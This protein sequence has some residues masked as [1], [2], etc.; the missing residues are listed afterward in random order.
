MTIHNNNLKVIGTR[1]LQ[2]EQKKVNQEKF[3]MNKGELVKLSN[4]VT[5]RKN[6]ELI[7]VEQ[8]D[9]T[10]II[11]ASDSDKIAAFLESN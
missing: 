10:I 7:I 3:L 8:S 6:A 1:N 9:Q 4:G 11:N 2:S 5:I